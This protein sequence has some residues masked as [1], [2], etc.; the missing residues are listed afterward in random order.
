MLGLALGDAFGAQFEGLSGE[1][2]RRRFASQP[3]LLRHRP[4]NG[5]FY[6]DDTQMAIGVAETLIACGAIEPEELAR[7]FAR[8][9]E[10]H[11]GYGRGARLVLEMMIDGG[12]HQNLAA[13][14]FPGGSYGNGAAMRVAPIGLAFC[15]GLDAVW[16]QAAASALPT[17][18][19]PLGIE[20]AQVLATAVALA[21]R[22]DVFDRSA[23]FAAISQRCKFAEYAGPL[24]RAARI[25]DPGDLELFGNGIEAASSVV[26]AI[27]CFGLTPDSFVDTLTNAVRLG[28]DTDTIAAMAGAV[29]G[30]YLGVGAL[31]QEF[32]NELENGRQGRG[33]LL[34]L[35]EGLHAR[36]T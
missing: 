3:E 25:K 31:P 23:F 15:D 1:T 35:A 4:P 6:T 5:L 36:R 17:H 13:T 28:G 27:A 24:R 21:V 7:R 34:Q 16:E 20:G 2:M 30:A 19:H 32:L 26:T 14:L 18:V 10:P 29:S 9:Y 22:S 8:N 33:Y 11:R 12:D